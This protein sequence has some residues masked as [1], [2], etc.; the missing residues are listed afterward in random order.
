MDDHIAFT[1]Q[2]MTAVAEQLAYE[3]M[4]SMHGAP[5]LVTDREHK[6]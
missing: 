1:L 3:A 2:A 6:H 4:R 5:A